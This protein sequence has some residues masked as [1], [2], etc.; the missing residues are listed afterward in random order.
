MNEFEQLL[1]ECTG[2]VERFVYYRMPSKSDGEDVLQEVYIA[3]YKSFD[4]LSD[5][6]KFKSWLLSIAM[7][8]CNDFYRKLHKNCEVPLDNAEYTHLLYYDYTPD[9]NISDTLAVLSADD[10]TLLQ[11]FYIE[12]MRQKEI[13]GIM[14]IPVGTVKSRLHAAKQR[15]KNLY[16]NRP[17]TKGANTMKE[18][19]KILP[20]IEITR[21]DKEPFEVKFEELPGWFI[22]PR[23]GESTE[24]GVYDSG[25]LTEKIPCTVIGEAEIH[26]IKCMEIQCGN[27]TLFAKLTD[28]HVQYLADIHCH[29]KVK[30]ITT[31]LDNDFLKNWSYGTDNCGRETLLK[32]CGSITYDGD[33]IT[34]AT[35]YTDDI[36]GRYEIVIGS[37]KYDTVLLTEIN[38]T[39]GIMIETYIDANGRTIL[40][41]RFNSDDW[42]ISR[43]KQKWSEQLPDNTKVTVNGKLYVNWYDCISDYIL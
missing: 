27:R 22:I 19:P 14:N 11:M 24:F 20:K 37:K 39:E 7:H 12:N 26:A 8:K 17:Y 23:K 31:F 25:R 13:A 5:K 42:Q 32:P 38:S 16:P 40:G 10:G 6:S 29:G 15:F 18:L 2:A 21:L 1:S 35:P 43:Y 30:S 36:A 41:R 28:T 9:D 33:E 4:K 3:A 34:S